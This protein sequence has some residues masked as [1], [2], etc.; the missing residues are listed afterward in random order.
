MGKESPKHSKKESDFIYRCSVL[1][2]SLILIVIFTAGCTS[3][4]I[5]SQYLPASNHTSPTS[6]PANHAESLKEQNI[7]TIKTIIE[8]YHQTHTYTLNDMYACAQMSQDVWD[9]VET[10]GINATIEVGDVD[11]NITTIRQANHAWV[12]AEVSPGEW[13]AMETTGGYLVCN[14]SRICAV[15]NPRYYTGWTFATPKDLQAYL[16]NPSGCSAGYILGTDNLCHTA[17]GVNTYCTGDSICVNGQCRGCNPGYIMGQDLQ[18]HPACGSTYC[19]GNGA[20]VNGQCISCNSGYILGTDNQCHMACG[21]NS[22]CSGNSACVNGQ[23]IGCTAG[24]YL[25]TD[26]RCHK[27]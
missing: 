2:L 18:C 8:E 26:L 16:N 17:C 19:T 9:M 20:C 12:R 10:K 21:A 11:Q 25:G 13:I 23:C 6:T 27:S 7:Q 1:F 15:S 14:N 3:N 24:Y 22:Y 5:A 4:P